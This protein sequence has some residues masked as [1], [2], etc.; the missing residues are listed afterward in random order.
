MPCADF[1]EY[2]T[3]VIVRKWDLCHNGVAYRFAWI[4]NYR[5]YIVLRDELSSRC[6]EFLITFVK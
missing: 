3:D 1:D 2:P 4:K 6:E 5:N